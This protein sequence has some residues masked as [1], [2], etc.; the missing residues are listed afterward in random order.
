M[1]DRALLTHLGRTIIA[2]LSI[3]LLVVTGVV[4]A[5]ITDDQPRIVETGQYR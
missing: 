3:T 4:Y 2:T 5:E 1:T